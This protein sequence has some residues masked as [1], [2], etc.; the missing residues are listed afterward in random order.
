MKALWEKMMNEPVLLLNLVNMLLAAGVAFGLDLTMEQ[1][2]AIIAVST[3]VLNIV[4]R[5]QVTPTRKL[6]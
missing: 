5:S 6:K 3:A 1:K 4:A 2:T